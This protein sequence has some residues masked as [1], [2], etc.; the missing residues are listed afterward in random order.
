MKMFKNKK[1]LIKLKIR[2]SKLYMTY[3]KYYSSNALI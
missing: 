1:G 3:I 2:Y